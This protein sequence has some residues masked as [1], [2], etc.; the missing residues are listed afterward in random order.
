[1]PASKVFIVTGA[2]KGIGAAITK[3]L[4]AGSHKVVLA[5]R[6]QE[7]LEQ[8]KTSH[9]GQVEYVAGDMASSDVSLHTSPEKI[10]CETKDCSQV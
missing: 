5:A 10:Q 1:M 7:L 3:Y 8:V 6:S 4:L 9:P 2:S